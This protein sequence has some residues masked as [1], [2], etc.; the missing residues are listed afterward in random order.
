VVVSGGAGG[1]SYPLTQSVGTI[2]LPV[3]IEQIGEGCWAVE[4]EDGSAVRVMTIN[5]VF[6]P[7]KFKKL[8]FLQTGR[9]LVVS[10]L[11]D[12]WQAIVVRATAKGLGYL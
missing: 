12:E 9:K 10:V 4:M 1:Y 11:Y 7:R 8:Y 2:M 6:S 5:Q 3:L